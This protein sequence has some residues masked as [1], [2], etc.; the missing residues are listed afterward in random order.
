MRLN[1][2]AAAAV[3]IATYPNAKGASMK[4]LLLVTP[5]L[6]VLAVAGCGGGSGYGGGSSSSS[7]SS[8]KPASGTAATLAL[9]NT[10]LGK[11]LTG[12]SGRTLY[13]FEKDK[14]AVSTCNGACASVW[15]PLTTTGK[16]NAGTSVDSAKL[17]TSKRSDGKQ[18]VVYAGHPLYYFTSDTKSGDTKGQNLNEFGAD[19]YAVSAAGQKVEKKSGS[20]GGSSS[21]SSGGGYHY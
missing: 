3:S 15:T 2:S 18:Q 11:I 10:G 19:W 16:P 7:S 9:G 5:A 17:T 4:R 13:L 21:T 12:A 14:S 20:S 8:S 6:L 1:R